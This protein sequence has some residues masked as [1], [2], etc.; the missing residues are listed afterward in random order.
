[1]GH[2]TQ[3]FAVAH[4]LKELL[5]DAISPKPLWAD[6]VTQVDRVAYRVSENRVVAGVHFPVDTW[7]G[8][9][10][11]VV[12]GRYAAHRFSG[13]DVSAPPKDF[14]DQ[15]ESGLRDESGVNG[16]TLELLMDSINKEIKPA[17]A[18]ARGPGT[19]GNGVLAEAWWR[20]VD[21]MRK[22]L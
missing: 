15:I 14:I 3:A 6:W 19:F 22:V 16:P 8:A 20:A 11:G 2:A 18:A 5:Q 17:T 4:V 21:E 1:M 12:L 10:L 9:E 7:A 13:R